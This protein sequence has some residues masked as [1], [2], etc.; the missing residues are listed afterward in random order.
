MRS[1]RIIVKKGISLSRGEREIGD[2]AI[3]RWFTKRRIKRSSRKSHALSANY[4]EDLRNISILIMAG[5]DHICQS[6]I[7]NLGNRGANIESDE[8]VGK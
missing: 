2:A 7:N 5:V 4:V 3:E 1:W 8:C 6:T